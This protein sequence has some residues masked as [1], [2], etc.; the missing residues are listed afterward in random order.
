M[1]SENEMIE[2]AVWAYAEA[3][4][5]TANSFRQSEEDLRRRFEVALKEFQNQTHFKKY[6][7]TDKCL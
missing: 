4:G 6:H 7:D 5:D 1:F 2:F 3:I